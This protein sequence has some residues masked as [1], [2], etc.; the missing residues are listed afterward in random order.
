L[1][2]VLVALG[3]ESVLDLEMSTEYFDLS[4]EVQA[5]L[6]FVSDLAVDIDNF[7]VH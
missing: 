1:E 4:S 5:D 7:V 2:T 6:D 3:V